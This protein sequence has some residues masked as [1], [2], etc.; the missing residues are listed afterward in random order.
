MTNH[1]WSS[2][3]TRHHED[4]QVAEVQSRDDP[5]QAD[6]IYRMTLR[7]TEP[8]VWRADFT[9]PDQGNTPGLSLAEKG[10]LVVRHT[11]R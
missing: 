11:P 8:G 6:P 5:D 2:D 10:Y 3:W 4:A 9:R 1:D 7:R